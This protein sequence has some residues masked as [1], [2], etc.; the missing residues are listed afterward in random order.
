LGSGGQR[1]EGEGQRAKRKERRG[2]EES[3]VYLFQI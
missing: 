2:N 3:K 1:A